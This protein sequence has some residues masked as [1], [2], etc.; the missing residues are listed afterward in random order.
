MARFFC[1]DLG[2]KIGVWR[3]W[4]K[5][6]DANKNGRRKKRAANQEERA[7]PSAR[8]FYLFLKRSLSR[9]R[10]VRNI[11][12]HDRAMS[13]TRNRF[14]GRVHLSYAFPYGPSKV[15]VR[16]VPALPKQT[17]EREKSD[18]NRGSRVNRCGDV[19]V[20][21]FF[22]FFFRGVFRSNRYARPDRD[23]L[24]PFPTES[25]PAGGVDI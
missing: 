25:I 21:G 22:F 1:E 5:G 18:R 24:L 20:N 2:A 17:K 9:P 3:Q 11:S 19:R 12:S 15:C 13:E 4:E 8:W 23:R 14:V 10:G 7:A 6:R 16:R